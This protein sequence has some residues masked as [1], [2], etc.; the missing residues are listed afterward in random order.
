[1]GRKNSIFING[2]LN[3]VWS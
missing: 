2:A 3:V 1:M